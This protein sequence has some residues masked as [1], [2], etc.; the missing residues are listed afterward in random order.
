VTFETAVERLRA[1]LA[2]PLP[3]AGAQDLLAPL[4]RREWPPGLNPARIRNAAGLL[5]I[6]PVDR[7][8][9]V[10]L[11]VRS[12]RVRH[13]GQVSLPGG[14]VE[15]GETFE[16][17]ALREAHEEVGLAISEAEPLGRL[18]PVDIP[19]S[20]FRLHP[21]VAAAFAPPALH[22]ADTE[23]ARIIEAD[24]AA[25]MEPAAFTF[26]TLTRDGRSLHVPTLVAGGADIWGATA[27]VLAEFLVLLGWSRPAHG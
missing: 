21:V 4:P 12:D 20:G 11:T 9:H 7:R 23:V 2:G 8:P 27:M 25:L 10:V 13:G 22:P 1:A 6:F 18:T 17:A 14:V 16:Q 24:V 26:K 5:L 3:G 15:R 19:V